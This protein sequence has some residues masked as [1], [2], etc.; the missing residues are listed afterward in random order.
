MNL[1]SFAALAAHG[2]FSLSLMRLVE[3]YD[4]LFSQQV[5]S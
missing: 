4:H 2:Y 5:S 1:P 3:K